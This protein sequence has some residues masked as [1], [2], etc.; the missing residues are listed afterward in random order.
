MKTSVNPWSAYI[1]V[2]YL[3]W[4][5]SVTMSCFIMVKYEKWNFK[6]IQS[7]TTHW[8]IK[9]NGYLEARSK[10]FTFT[11]RSKRWAALCTL[12]S[13]SAESLHRASKILLKK[14]IKSPLTTC[15]PV[16][17]SMLNPKQNHKMAWNINQAICN[18]NSY[19]G[20]VI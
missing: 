13:E 15:M 17:N 11:S 14:I 19:L 18:M 10:Y 3:N 4:S 1:N 20:N 5:L 2:T 6:R 9:I 8:L 16:E 12:P 7:Y